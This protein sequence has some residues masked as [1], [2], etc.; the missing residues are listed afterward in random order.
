MITRTHRLLG[1]ALVAAV[2]L[3][4]TVGLSGTAQASSS[5]VVGHVYQATNNAKGNAIAVFDRTANGSLRARGTVS[6]GGQG[7]GASLGSQGAVTREGSLLFV[8]NG[9]DDSVSV[10]STK[11]GSLHLRDRIS[12]SGAHPVSGTRPPGDG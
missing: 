2:A 4:A 11:S 5:P 8:V 7:T 9:G 12:P 3:G 10:L 6:T 1:R